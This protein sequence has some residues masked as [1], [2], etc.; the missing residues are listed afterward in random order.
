MLL[1]I[2]MGGG[3]RNGKDASISLV[4]QYARLSYIHTYG[5]GIRM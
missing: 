2:G 1:F 4:I 5:I 3:L